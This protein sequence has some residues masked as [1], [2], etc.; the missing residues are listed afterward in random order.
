MKKFLIV[1]LLLPSITLAQSQRNPCYNPNSINTQYENC[2]GVGV[3]SPLP[4]A[5]TGGITYSIGIDSYTGYATPTDIVSIIGLATKKIKIFNIRVSGFATANNVVQVDLIK[6]STVDTGG[7]PTSYVGVPL[8]S[9][10]PIP[11]A[12]VISYGS[13]PTLGTQ[14]GGQLCACQVEIP[15]K[16]GVGGYV[17]QWNFNVNGGSPLVLHGI[18]EMVALN[19]LST[20]L[21]SG[22]TL[23]ITIEWI[24]E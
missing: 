20:T 8:D 13:A 22:G 18:N 9:V 3:N 24:E 1:L 19:L 2:I 6:R 16:A 23:N 5:Q 12:T 15:A 10:F 4:I 17:L 11:T 7:T 14:I 21:P